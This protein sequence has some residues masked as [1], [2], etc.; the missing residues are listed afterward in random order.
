M[1]LLVRSA[2]RVDV[3][4]FEH[5]SGFRAA[6]C[7]VAPF[8]TLLFVSPPD[9]VYVALGSLNLSMVNAVPPAQTP[10]RVLAVAALLLPAGMAT[11]TVMA[12]LGWTAVLLVGLAVCALQLMAIE[13]ALESTGLIASVMLVVGVGLPGGGVT[14]ASDR[15]PLVLLGALIGLG[16]VLVQRALTRAPPAPPQTDS[17][18]A[19][20]RPGRSLVVVHSAAV[21]ATAA[22]GLAIGTAL[23]LQRDFWVMLTVLVALR[24]EFTDTLAY[25]WMRVLGTVAG[26]T[27]AAAVSFEVPSLTV[28]AI[29][30]A[31]ACAAAFALRGVNYT[32]FAAALT[33]WV[34][35]TLNFVLTG[36]VHLAE[37]RI[38]DTVIGGLLATGTGTLLYLLHESRRHLASP[39]GRPSG[40]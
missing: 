40:G 31:L 2:G 12:P 26:A 28:Q 33:V 13:P 15:F 19:P 9:A 3:K 4:R 16:G 7:V 38:L 11:G 37:V 22:A 8:L 36:G 30:I 18:L 6:I 24:L 35:L 1:A 5:L 14:A 32:L 29:A 34:I 27:V 21:G 23:G 10:A 39:T 17:P 25:A 20:S